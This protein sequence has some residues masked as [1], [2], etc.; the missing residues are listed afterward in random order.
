MANDTTPTCYYNR[1][2][3][4][5]TSESLPCGGSTGQNTFCC[6]KGHICMDDGI[7]LFNR[8]INGT[9]GY[10][11][12]GCTDQ[13]FRDPACSK[14]C[15]RYQAHDVVYNNTQGLW[16]CCYSSE[17]Q[18]SAN[19]ANPG[20]ESFKA[21]PPESLSAQPSYTKPPLSSSTALTSTTSTTTTAPLSPEAVTS[22]TS[23]SSDHLSSGTKA[24]IGVGVAIAVLAIIT[25]LLF[26]FLRKRST[27]IRKQEPVFHDDKAQEM[28]TDNYR[29]QEMSAEFAGKPHVELDGESRME[30]GGRARLE[31]DAR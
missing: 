18:T 26:V 24:G 25:V 21:L 16:H 28:G 19:C 10:Y 5:E 12:G 7:C 31:L 27:G 6:A 4:I 14:R 3:N 11:F 8:K 29:A 30:I 17:D 15:A 20:S 13:T 1:A 23:S 2:G 9:S 22:P